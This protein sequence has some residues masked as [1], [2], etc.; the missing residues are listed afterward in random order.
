MQAG[1]WVPHKLTLNHTIPCPHPQVWLLRGAGGVYEGFYV[2]RLSILHTELCLWSVQTFAV[3]EFQEGRPGIVPRQIV[4]KHTPDKKGVC[5]FILKS[6][7]S[8]TSASFNMI[9]SSKQNFK[10]SSYVFLAYQTLSW[11]PLFLLLLF[12]N[13][14]L[15]WET[16]YLKTLCCLLSFSRFV[17]INYFNFFLSE[18]KETAWRNT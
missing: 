17:G 9:Y 2:F 13:Y 18:C 3:I 8:V 7:L 6:I 12:L 16:G 10:Q 5:M 4:L 1:A 14:I 11:P 15:N